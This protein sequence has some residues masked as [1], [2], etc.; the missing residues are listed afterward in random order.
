MPNSNTVMVYVH[1]AMGKFIPNVAR[2]LGF[3]REAVNQ[4][5]YMK[6]S[7]F[8][9]NVLEKHSV[10]FK[11]IFVSWVWSIV[12]QF[13]SSDLNQVVSE[14]RNSSSIFIQ[15]NLLP[16]LGKFGQLVEVVC[17]PR[18]LFISAILGILQYIFHF[19]LVSQCKS[20]IPGCNYK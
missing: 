4:N 18:G 15:A 17:I 14:T 20:P 10:I 3:S 9:I 8:K 19:Q 1:V 5:F 16:S 6:F 11:Y 13:S 12:L 7:C 2:S